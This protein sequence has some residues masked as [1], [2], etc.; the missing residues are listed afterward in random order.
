[1]ATPI[2]YVSLYVCIAPSTVGSI[3]YR[4]CYGVKGP[5]CSRHCTGRQQNMVPSQRACKQNVFNDQLIFAAK[6]C[7]KTSGAKLHVLNDERNTTVM[8]HSSCWKNKMSMLCFYLCRESVKAGFFFFFSLS[9]D[10]LG[11]VC[12]DQIVQIRG[13]EMMKLRSSWRPMDHTGKKAQM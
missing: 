10:Y 4:H 1:M 3:S 11:I 8:A 13:P 6:S 5:Y 2:S 9:P 12:K 7:R